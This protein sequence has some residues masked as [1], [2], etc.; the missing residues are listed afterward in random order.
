MT[1]VSQSPGSFLSGL[2]CRRGMNRYYPAVV[3]QLMN[4]GDVSRFSKSEFGLLVKVHGSGSTVKLGSYVLVFHDD[5]SREVYLRETDYLAA[6]RRQHELDHGHEFRVIS[7]EYNVMVDGILE[8]SGMGCDLPEVPDS[9]LKNNVLEFHRDVLRRVMTGLA[10]EVSVVM[11]TLFDFVRTTRRPCAGTVHCLV[12]A[13][14]GMLVHKVVME[15]VK[16]GF[17]DHVLE[18]IEFG[19][20]FVSRCSYAS[21]KLILSWYHWLRYTMV[22]PSKEYHQESGIDM[23]SEQLIAYGRAAKA[24]SDVRNA[25]WLHY[26]AGKW[27]SRHLSPGFP[28][29]GIEHLNEVVCLEGKCAGY[30]DLR[31][32]YPQIAILA[33]MVM[34]FEPR[35]SPF[36]M[37]VFKEIMAQVRRNPQD[38]GRV[39]ISIRGVKVL[40]CGLKKD[41]K[42]EVLLY[43]C[44]GLTLTSVKVMGRE[45]YPAQNGCAGAHNEGFEWDVDEMSKQ[46]RCNLNINDPDWEDPDGLPV[47]CDRVSM[48]VKQECLALVV[49]DTNMGGGESRQAR[50]NKLKRL[51]GA[52]RGKGLRR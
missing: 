48:E 24:E 5:P 1:K 50:K 9:S 4:P 3:I 37:N 42:P 31:R 11:F 16:F 34:G 43:Y 52:S 47:V 10:Y 8:R 22:C 32:S 46:V 21:S 7:L 49:P 41:E 20:D 38:I 30:S 12:H 25:V 13:P 39:S 44:D 14:F 23:Y 19:V 45:S 28:E 51:Q 29:K 40:P 35:T 26:N 6:V 2:T 18:V 33:K 15:M 17:S 36:R 27:F